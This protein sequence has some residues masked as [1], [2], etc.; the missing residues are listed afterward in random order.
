MNDVYLIGLRLLAYA[1][2]SI[3]GLWIMYVCVMRL[4]MLRD[5][6]QLTTGIKIFGYPT[7]LI[8]LLLD[9]VVNVVVCTV[10]F[11][12]PPKEWTVS[13]RLWRHS[14]DGTGWRRRLAFILRTQL[15][16]SVDPSGIHRG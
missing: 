5:A 15:L 7:L 6:G 12:E 3:W 9:T 4:Q 1:L 10:L 14:E 2:L 13:A 11:M 16:D 8:G